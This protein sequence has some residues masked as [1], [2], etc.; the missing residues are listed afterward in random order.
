MAN[1]LYI[2]N[3][4]QILFA[5]HSTDFGAAPATAANSIILG[6]PTDVQIDMTSLAASGG[7]RQSAKADLGADLARGTFIRVDACVEHVSTYPVDGE[8]MVFYWA[9]SHSA[10]A[11][12][13][14]PGKATGSDAAYTPSIGGNAQMIRIG[15]LSC[16][17]TQFNI[18][19][20]GDFLPAFRYGSLIVINNTAVNMHTVMD[21]AHIT[22]TPVVYVPGA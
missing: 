15:S 14:N 3:G 20:V 4:T 16:Q 1:E 17:L 12:T 2:Q 7:A 11:A 6:T 18:G 22:L 10:T 8:S 21:E 5:D 19:Y 13:G 9:P